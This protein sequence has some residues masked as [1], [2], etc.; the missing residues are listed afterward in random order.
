MLYKS[1]SRC[2]QLDS[3]TVEELRDLGLTRYEAMCY[4]SLAGL[5]PADPRR[6]AAEAG[7]PYPNA[8]EALSR[9]ANMGW[10]ELVKKRPATYRARRPE[11]IKEM[12][13]S[14]LD[15]TFKTLCAALQGRPSA[16]MP[17]WST[18]SAAGR[19]SS[20]RCTR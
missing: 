19:R 13:A 7:I 10:V 1:F 14:K 16:K 15:G 4:I 12:I 17:S 6:I 18:R 5:G 11:S 8:Y 9:L 2:E 20:R 3:A